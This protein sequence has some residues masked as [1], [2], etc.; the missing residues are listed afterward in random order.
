MSNMS[1]FDFNLINTF[2]GILHTSS[3]ISYT[4]NKPDT[5]KKDFTPFINIQLKFL[6]KTKR[7]IQ[8]PD[9]YVI[10]KFESF[11]QKTNI[12]TCTVHEYLDE[13]DNL[14]DI[15]KLLK[16]LS[17]CHWTRKYDKL[18]QDIVETDLTPDRTIFDESIEI[19]SIDP[20]GCRDIDDALHCIKTKNGWQ[21]GI[22]IADVSSYI[23]EGSTQD[24]ELAKRGETFYSDYKSFSHQNMIPNI[25]SLEHASL[26]D[27]K[28]SRSFTVLVDFDDNYN[29]VNVTFQKSLIKVK[30]NLSYEKAQLLVNT[31]QNDSIVNLYDFGKRLFKGLEENY[32]THEM[33]AVFM[34]LA[35]KLVAEHLVKVNPLGVIL[36]VQNSSV[37][38]EISCENKILNDKYLNSLNERATYVVGFDCNLSHASLGCYTHFTSPIRRYIDILVHRALY[39]SVHTT[40]NTIPNI[41][42][43]NRINEY[44]RVYKRLQRH[45]KLLQK[46]ET[47]DLITEFDAHIISLKSD[48]NMIRVYIEDLDLEVDIK[49]FNKKLQQIIENISDNENELAIINTQ[50]ACGIT[51][52]LFQKITIQIVLT[53]NLFSPI[54]TTIIEPNIQEILNIT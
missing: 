43:I 28:I 17:T 27:T 49:V 29:V 31:K 30:E 46:I 25:I 11:D 37:A 40:K 7:I 32:D 19:Y 2:V 41:E 14:I 23:S 34:I 26:L 24:L 50:T 36:R 53:Q 15:N 38:P 48:R 52:A 13:V 3:V 33:V 6:V 47:L 8:S 51:L 45:T 21:I 39:E 9:L 12:V 42:T 44:S 1:N 10:A 5:I 4:T 22:H 35:N 54:T 16:A 20:E 18:F